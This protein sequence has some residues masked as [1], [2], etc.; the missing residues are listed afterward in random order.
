MPNSLIFGFLLLSLP[1]ALLAQE[2]S[3]DSV[4]VTFEIQVPESTPAGAT[5][6]WAGSLNNWDPGN[7]GSGFG[8]KEYAEPATYNDGKWKLSLTAPKGSQETYKYTRGSVYSAEEQTD[9]TYHPLREVIFDESKTIR[10]TV[11][12]WH[13][14]PPESLQEMWPL[15]NLRETAL[16]IFYGDI[17]MDGTGTIVY[18]EATGSRF[19]D[20]PKEA[21]KVRE[22]PD[23]FYDTVYYYQKI[24]PETEALLLI[25][26]AKMR[27]EG[28]WHLFVDANGDKRI[29]MAERTFKIS[30]KNQK[31]TWTG[32]VFNKTTGDSIEFTLRY[33]P[34]LPAGYTSSTGTDAPD[35]MYSMPFKQREGIVNDHT[36]YLSAEK[37]HQFSNYHQ[38]LIDKDRNDTLEIGSGSNEVYTIN[39]N[40]MRME[41]K[42]FLYP[43]LQLGDQSWQIANIDPKGNW[44]RLRPSK[45]DEFGTAAIAK[46]K[47]APE[48]E[49]TTINSTTLSSES[50][51]GKYLLLDFWGS[52]CGPCIEEIPNLKKAYHNYKE[53]NFELISF[54]YE[55]ESSLK[56]ALKKYRLPWPQVLD[57]KG[58]FSKHF[59]VRG[60]PTQYLISP[61][62]RILEMG[63]ELRGDQLQATLEKYLH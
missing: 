9:Y 55:S 22:I 26:A 6:F 31:Q 30:D 14:I 25:A 3:T 46:G 59:K 4:T 23:N 45:A 63:K 58:K 17:E 44:I 12:A 21:A 27:P 42:Y 39:F 1:N 10:D 33:A 32:P 15:I 24:A 62:G 18:D 43:S 35:L 16:Q 36:F 29:G 51:H 53:K 19:Y 8:A 48:W 38:F 20:I 40:Q 57:D 49:A 34:D 61:D 28:P 11:A 60:Y 54:A 2:F 37:H 5:I 41:Q 52:W 13:D 56:Q 7:K 50:L 47:A